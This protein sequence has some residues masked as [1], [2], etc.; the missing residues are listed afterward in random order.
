MEEEDVTS[1]SKVGSF[2]GDL[3]GGEGVTERKEYDAFV[4]N[5]MVKLNLL[6]LSK[7]DKR[8]TNRRGLV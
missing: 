3:A 6:E 8:V 7:P 5:E 2:A 1:S 4:G